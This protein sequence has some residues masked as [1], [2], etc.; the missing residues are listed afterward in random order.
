MQSKWEEVKR[1][2]VESNRVFGYKRLKLHERKRELIPLLLSL[3]A[4]VAVS[5]ALYI[6][7]NPVWP[8]SVM[9][10]TAISMLVFFRS[11]ERMLSRVY[12]EEYKKYHISKQRV[13]ER[14]DYLAYAFF[15]DSI[16]G[17]GYAPE[18]LKV[19]SDYSETLN[20]PPK[21]FL[22][23]Q[24]FV[25]VILVSTLVSLF[26]AYL[27]KT[28]AWPVQASAYI[29]VVAALAVVVS[30]GLDGLRASKM[31]EARIR[32]YIKRAQIELEHERNS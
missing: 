24:H 31:R 15:I 14:V 5:S 22:I 29:F 16:R 9:T 17:M 32:C 19:I 13:S 26:A 23:N 8:M 7:E 11:L 20:P 18:D 4:M 27:Q 3:L 30:I 1:I 6:F 10:G 21:P 28:P 12:P 25:P 2:Y